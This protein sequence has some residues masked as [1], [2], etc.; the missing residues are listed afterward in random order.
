ME[1]VLA[2]EETSLTLKEQ[3]VLLVFLDHCFNSLVGGATIT[4]SAS[5]NL[6]GEASGILLVAVTSLS[7]DRI[8]V[9]MS[10]LSKP[11]T[12]GFY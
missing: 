1:A 5:T 7:F 6:L 10:H 12:V 2:G 4:S 11:G 8:Y 3:T 9:N